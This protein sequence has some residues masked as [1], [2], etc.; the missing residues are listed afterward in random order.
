MKV[1]EKLKIL[2][3][4]DNESPNC[5]KEGFSVSECVKCMQN[6]SQGL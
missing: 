3:P 4:P 5:S 1:F 2:R 6:I